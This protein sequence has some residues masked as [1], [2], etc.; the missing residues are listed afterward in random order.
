MGQ[1]LTEEEE[2]VQVDLAKLGKARESDSWTRPN[3]FPPEKM[4]AQTEDVV[5]SRWVLTRKEV[6]GWGAA[7]TH[8]LPKGYQRPDPRDGNVGIAGCVWRRLSHL[9]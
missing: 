4:G 9:Q 2:R 8:V 5:D 3:V 6:E 1:A 7:Q